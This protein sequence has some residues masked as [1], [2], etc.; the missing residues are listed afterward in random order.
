MLGE[1]LKNLLL[2]IFFVLIVLLTINQAFAFEQPMSNADYKALFP[3]R[4]GA[5]LYLQ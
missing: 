4:V 5:N 2:T 3:L 1:Q